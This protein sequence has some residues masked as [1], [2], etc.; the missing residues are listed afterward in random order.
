MVLPL[1]GR[2]ET[3]NPSRSVV[4]LPGFSGIFCHTLPGHVTEILGFV[5]CKVEVLQYLVLRARIVPIRS[6][7]FCGTQYI[8]RTE[9]LVA[10][11]TG[12]AHPRRDNGQDYQK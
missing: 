10:D 7:C 4:T 2:K 3:Q 9:S 5:N 1:V 6:T 12:D 11:V 8:H